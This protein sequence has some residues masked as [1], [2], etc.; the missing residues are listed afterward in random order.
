MGD[1]VIRIGLATAS[2]GL[3]LTAINRPTIG[4][5]QVSGTWCVLETRGG[6][7]RRVADLLLDSNRPFGHYLPLV[8][9][10]RVYASKTQIVDRPLFPNYLFA[11]YNDSGEL[12]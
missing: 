7:E 6:F 8:K 12:Y 9:V 11:A 3:M 2:A 10:R 4:V 5:S 1:I